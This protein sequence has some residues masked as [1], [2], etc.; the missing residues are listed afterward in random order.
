MTLASACLKFAL[1]LD[2]ELSAQFVGNNELKFGRYDDDFHPVFLTSC[3]TVA[4]SAYT[5]TA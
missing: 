2:V 3:A 1:G 5:L 4:L